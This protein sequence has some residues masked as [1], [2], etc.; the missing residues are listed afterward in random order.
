MKNPKNIG[1][2]IGTPN[3]NVFEYFEFE[4][5]KTE[6]KMHDGNPFIKFDTESKNKTH[7]LFTIGVKNSFKYL[8]Y[9]ELS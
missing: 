6:M 2:E 9:G 5:K 4:P 7:Y 1:V 8:F 3:E